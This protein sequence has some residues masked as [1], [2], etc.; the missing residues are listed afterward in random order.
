MRF[1]AC[2]IN[3]LLTKTKP[4][5][6]FQKKLFTKLFVCFLEYVKT[7]SIFN[8]GISISIIADFSVNQLHPR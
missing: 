4:Q 1:I 2:K 8:I 7:F 5:I 6:I 3:N